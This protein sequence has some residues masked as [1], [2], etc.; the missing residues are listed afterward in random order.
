M[1]DPFLRDRLRKKFTQAYHNMG[2]LDSRSRRYGYWCRAYARYLKKLHPGM[3]SHKAE[4]FL[5][6]G[7]VL[8]PFSPFVSVPMQSRYE[9]RWKGIEVHEHWGNGK[10]VVKFI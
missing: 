6:S 1:Q 8:A 10:T 7:V 2:K 3:T 9:E 5:R 4:D